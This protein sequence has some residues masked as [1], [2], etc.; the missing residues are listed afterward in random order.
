M[1]DIKE[2]AKWDKILAKRWADALKG[3]SAEEHMK[4]PAKIAESVKYVKVSKEELTQNV[5]HIFKEYLNPVLIKA[6]V[7]DIE[8]RIPMSATVE[9]MRPLVDW[10]IN[11]CENEATEFL[12]V[13]NLLPS[14]QWDNYAM[15]KINDL[16]EVRML[17]KVKKA[18]LAKWR[19]R[20]LSIRRLYRRSNNEA[21]N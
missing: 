11:I 18:F 3:Q 12:K 14:E 17:K 4:E 15:F 16:V 1:A 21:K 9:S 19:Q 10:L 20:P 2:T 7:G 13:Y 5:L 6:G 8:I